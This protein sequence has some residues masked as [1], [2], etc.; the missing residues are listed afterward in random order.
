MATQIR[1]AKPSPDGSKLAFT[2]L[3]RLYVMDFP[4]GTPRRLTQ[5]N[6]IEAQPDWSPDGKYLVFTTWKE[7][8]GHLYK[9]NVDGRTRI[10][11]LTQQTGLYQYP[12]WSYK[13]NRIAFHR[14]ATQSFQDLLGIYNRQMFEDF[15][16]GFL[17]KEEMSI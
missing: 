3:N 11:Q 9:V 8:G 7:G 4:N 16:V 10:T 14:G 15:D 2:A 1:D 6:F 17:P 13:S 12:E 5:N